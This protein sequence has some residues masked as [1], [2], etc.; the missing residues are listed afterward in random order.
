MGRIEINGV[1]LELDLMD[2]DVL[3]KYEIETRKIG[4]EFES[5]EKGGL[6]TASDLRQRI[7]R[8]DEYID[9]LF[10]VGT[11]DRIFPDKRHYNDR[12]IA[13]GKINTVAFETRRE[14]DAIGREYDPK[15][16]ANRANRAQRRNG[17]KKKNHGQIR[18]V[19]EP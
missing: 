16:Y 1:E 5:F 3:E 11:S 4:E 19:V 6:T 13:F 17:N 18:P 14:V 9:T 15:N 12:M 7:A 2:V 8:V 10:G